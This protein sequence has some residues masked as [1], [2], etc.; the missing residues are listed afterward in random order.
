MSLS[1][2]SKSK[3]FRKRSG[4]RSVSH[5]GSRAGPQVWRKLGG[6]YSR[7]YNISQPKGG[8][9][10]G[11]RLAVF[12]PAKRLIPGKRGLCQQG[13]WTAVPRVAHMRAANFNFPSLKFSK[14]LRA[15][16]GTKP[17][18]IDGSTDLLPL[19]SRLIVLP[20]FGTEITCPA[21]QMAS[22]C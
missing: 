12:A 16:R 13:S 21:R 15:F 1:S 10:L 17:F 5:G 22:V 9:C 14:R 6:T 20:V 19:L 18:K 7:W 2:E 4:V 11:V 8:M 3:V